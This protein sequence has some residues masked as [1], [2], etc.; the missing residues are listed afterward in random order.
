MI[1][2]GDL[3]GSVRQA[4]KTRRGPSR[5]RHRRKTRRWSRSRV[6]GTGV[7]HDEDLVFAQP[8]GRPID[9]R[10]DYDDSTRLLR[11]AGVRHV[12]LHDGCHTAAT[13]LLSENVHP[14]VVMEL[15][16]HSQMRM[17]MD[18]YRHVMPAWPARPPTG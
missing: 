9:K 17:T 10:S 12:R 15:L 3:P 13:L 8:N 18:I 16:G 6:L 4:P 14:L 5:R 2:H 7:R 1:A 11:S